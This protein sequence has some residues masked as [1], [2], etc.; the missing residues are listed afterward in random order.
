MQDLITAPAAPSRAS[1]ETVK[2]YGRALLDAHTALCELQ[3]R[4]EAIDG[5]GDAAEPLFRAFDR[6]ADAVE[7]R[8]ALGSAEMANP[9][10]IGAERIPTSGREGG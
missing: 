1:R 7:A 4:V 8:F 3:K 6:V 2:A 9:N 10:E 5:T